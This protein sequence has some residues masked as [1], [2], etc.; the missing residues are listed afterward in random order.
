MNAIRLVRAD[1]DL[2]F[3]EQGRSFV[4]LFSGHGSVWLGHGNPAIVAAVTEQLRHL[5]TAGGLP[6]T[7]GDQ[8][9]AA[10]ETW[11]PANYRV[12]ALYS[13]GMEAAEFALRVA[14]VATGRT[15]AMGFAR[16]MH[17]KSL[18]TAALAWSDPQPS[19]VPGISHWPL[20]I[21]DLPVEVERDLAQGDTSAVFVEPWQAS[22][23][24]HAATAV[25]HRELAECCRE[26]STLLVFDEI[27]TGFH[28]TGP[29]FAF[30]EIGVRPDLILIGKALGNGFPVSAVV[31]DRAI[32]ITSAMLPG[33]TFAGNPLA[34][35][36]I[37]VTLQEMRRHDLTSLVHVLGERAF[38][39]L[40]PLE[41]LGVAVR[42]Q[43]A[44]WVLELPP[45]ADVSAIVVRI[46]QSGVAVGTTGRLI[47]LLPAVTIA[48]SRWL[49][50]LTIVRDRIIEGC[51]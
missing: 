4:D 35:S 41:N 7:I 34:S 51:A 14:R 22:G 49:D 40:E 20:P 16:S 18:A 50:A 3:D 1:N 5:W 23:G 10:I 13:T 33:S 30:E 24:G 21:G 46:F 47:R 48:P 31:V 12:A 36:A 28:R 6:T 17:G 42:G 45:T 39:V 43:G 27:L 26:H 19:L 29:A 37:V 44:L 32:E 15:K 8:A 38:N 2:L 25:C 9:R 11:F